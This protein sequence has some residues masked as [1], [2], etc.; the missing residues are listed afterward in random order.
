MAQVFHKEVGDFV[1]IGTRVAAS[2]LSLMSHG[3]S[4]TTIDIPTSIVLDNMVRRHFGLSVNEWK[5]K[6]E[7]AAGSNKLTIVKAN[8]LSPSINSTHLWETIRNAP[9]IYLDT[10]HKPDSKPFE[11]EFIQHLIN[12]NY[13]GVVLLDDI[14]LNFE[15]Q[16]LF[17]ALVCTANAPYHAYD[18]TVAGHSSGTGLLDFE[19]NRRLQKGA[20]AYSLVVGASD[21]KLA[22]KAKK[23]SF[24]KGGGQLQRSRESSS[25]DIPIQFLPLKCENL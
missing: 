1:D 18:V 7:Q 20:G 12:I 11:R 22:E 14:Y 4:V 10:N 23:F 17:D 8:L 24:L 6:V 2:S 5:L 21:E 25:P 15:M 3:H 9:L 13:D 16:K 19:Y